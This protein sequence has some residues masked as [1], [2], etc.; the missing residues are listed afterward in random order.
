MKLNQMTSPKKGFYLL[1]ALALGLVGGFLACDDTAE[2]TDTSLEQAG[3][4]IADAAHTVTEAV[5][6]SYAMPVTAN[7]LTAGTDYTLSITPPS[8]TATRAVTID[9]DG[10]ITITTAIVLA[11]GGTYT[12][13]ATG[14]D[15]YE[16][17]VTGDFVLTV[18]KVTATEIAKRAVTD[19]RD[20]YVLF[21]IS[22]NKAVTDYHLA[23]KEA[24]A[25]APTAGEMTSGAL[26]RNLGT[27]AIN[28]LIAQRM[29][30]P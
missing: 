12:V 16:G 8:S 22:A 15:N 7:G 20:S 4:T 25:T 18:F 29:N 27:D 17:T 3:L 23:V 9:D 14:K 11:D 19:V 2:G 26:K 1:F 6:G 24:N 5:G 21:S 28:V 13:T 10:Q 30:A